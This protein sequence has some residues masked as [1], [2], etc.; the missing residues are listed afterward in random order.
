[1]DRAPKIPTL[2]L[3]SLLHRLA[4]IPGT[5]AN[6]AGDLLHALR[7][8]NQEIARVKALITEHRID[9]AST[10]SD[11]SVRRWLQRVS[12]ALYSDLITLA[13][14]T[15]DDPS[16]ASLLSELHKRAAQQIQSGA[17]LSL[18]ELAISGSDLMRELH[19]QPGPQIGLLL[20]R[21]LADVMEDSSLNQRQT[22]LARASA[23]L[24]QA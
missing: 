24:A 18:K 8:S 6:K 17:P 22:L 13:E 16:D 9:Y 10:W 14:I 12:T 4:E 3:A 21:L 1:L 15:S 19:L 20:E 2:Q 23:L 7:F 11:A 5:A